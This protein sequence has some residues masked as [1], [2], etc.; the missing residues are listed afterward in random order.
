MINKIKQLSFFS[1]CSEETLH[2]L[3]QKT[4][5]IEYS[6]NS[7]MTYEEDDINRVHFLLNGEAKLYKVDKLDSEIFLYTT[8]SDSLLTNLGSMS[9]ETI[10]CFSNIEF[11]E[12]S[13]VISFDM[14]DFKT[15]VKGSKWLLINLLDC[16]SFQKQ[17]IECTINVGLVYDATSKVAH[18]LYNKLDIFNSLKKQ[19]IAYRLNLQPATLS[20]I[21]AKLVRKELITMQGSK[22]S[23]TDKEELFM[24]YHT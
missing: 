22:V 18:M 11:I 24:L 13:T 4:K 1:K 19:E 3:V 8:S 7:I 2:K 15:I 17:Q 14:Y 10:S 5:V 9:S 23:I 21:L 16:V 6:K 20:R 12:K